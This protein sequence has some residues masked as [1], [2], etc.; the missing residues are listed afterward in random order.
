MICGESNLE[1]LIP[2]TPDWLEAHGVP[3]SLIEMHHPVGEAHDRELIV[4][5]CRNCHAK[6]TEGLMRAGISMRPGP[7]PK[8]RVPLM[9]DALAVFLDMLAAAV[10]RWARVLLGTQGPGDLNG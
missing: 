9:L 2:L 3:R 10:R 1:T 6:A 7:D 4:P 5:L 8:A